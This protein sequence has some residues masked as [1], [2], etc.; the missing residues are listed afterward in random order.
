MKKNLTKL[1]VTA[2][3]IGALGV[4]GSFGTFSAFTAS[5]T[6]NTTFS[7]GTVKIENEFN[8]PWQDLGTARRAA[9]AG[10]NGA[11]AG[12][13]KVTNTGTEPIN[14]FID[15]DGTVDNP[16]WQIP[17]GANSHSTNLLAENLKI[18]SSYTS[19]FAQLGDDS[20]R[21]WMLNR[22]GLSP[23]PDPLTGKP[24][25]VEPGQSKAIY[26]R[27]W[28]RERDASNPVLAEQGDGG[29]DNAMQGLSIAEKVTVKAIEA[30]ADDLPITG[31][32]YDNGL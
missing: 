29:D 4:A 1:G 10:G 25:V 2:A 20:T 30:G 16:N 12:H 27:A 8:L 31:I 13:V 14:V 23:L 9:F 7:A 28:L 6:K 22:R 17:S 24:L 32:P 5:E 3:A 26:Y 15:F 11:S 18:D 21:L 19:D